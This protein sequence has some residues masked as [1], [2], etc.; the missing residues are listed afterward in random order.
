MY[1]ISEYISKETDTTVIMSGEGSDEVA[2]GYIY[3]RDSPS[4]ADAHKE[5]LRLLDDIHLYDGLRADRTIA[6]HRFDFNQ[7]IH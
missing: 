5:S 3:F 7:I 2:Q 1:L 4:A 6:A